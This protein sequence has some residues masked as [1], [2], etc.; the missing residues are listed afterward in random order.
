V[1]EH[2]ITTGY[3]TPD[4]LPEYRAVGMGFFPD[5]DWDRGMA[6][7]RLVLA[8]YPSGII[9]V[10]NAKGVILGYLALFPIT[11]EAFRKF[12]EGTLT[13]EDFDISCLPGM[14]STKHEHWLLRTIAVTPHDRDERRT[15]IQAL[16]KEYHA[17][18]EAS[19]P[20]QVIAHASTPA[21]LRFLTRCGFEISGLSF[22][23]FARRSY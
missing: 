9:V 7:Y 10:R 18:M 8:R 13:D 17:R 5:A 20:C 21:G 12:R 1:N 14:E 23:Y 22:P 11:P 16:L 2:G 4:Q 3:L 15:V 6:G 19:R